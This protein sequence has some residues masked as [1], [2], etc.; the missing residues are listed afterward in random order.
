VID[1]ADLDSSA[2][3][4]CTALVFHIFRDKDKHA[5]FDLLLEIITEG[6]DQGYVFCDLGKEARYYSRRRTNFNRDARHCA[7]EALNVPIFDALI[8]LLLKCCTENGF[9]QLI[10]AAP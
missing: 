10:F 2:L 7:T 5:D 1:N 3:A 9:I 6:S 8:T 4:V